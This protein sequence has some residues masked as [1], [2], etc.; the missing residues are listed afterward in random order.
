MKFKNIKSVYISIGA[1]LLVAVLFSSCE[2]YVDIPK[3]PNQLLVTDA[4]KEDATATSAV[5]TLY[6][7]DNTTNSLGY[8]SFCGGLEADELE[9]ANDNDLSMN[10][11]QTTALSIKN[12]TVQ[13]YL[14]ATPYAV[15][16]TANVA[17][18][19]LNNSTTLTPSVKNQLLGESKFFRA[20]TYFYLVNYFGK[21]PLSLSGDANA[22]AFLPRASTD[23]VYAQIVADLKDAQTLLPATYVGT[24][25]ARVNKYAATALLA[26]IYLYMN[27]YTNAEIQASNVIGATDIS[28]TMQD[29]DHAFLNTS[30]EVIF[31]IAPTTSWSSLPILGTYYNSYQQYVL[32]PSFTFEAGDKRATAWT[33]GNI[34]TK[35]KMAGNEYNVTLRLAEQYLIRSEARAQLAKIS[36]AQADLDSVRIRAGLAKT[37]ASTKDDL[38]T[39]IAGERKVELVG[40][41]SH[42]WFDL[43]RTGKADQVIGALKPATWKSTAVLAPIPSD[44]RFKNP[45]LTQ[46][47]GYPN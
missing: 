34:I 9:N 29:I 40:E 41:F 13:N 27:D 5:L 4:F 46:N 31:Q 1:L 35:Y 26:R 15:I 30:N 33:D 25:R 38:L 17:I 12:S 11:F 37:T 23:S 19:G 22:N 44:E 7:N 39:A 10:E 47:D 21:V 36:G 16:G 2:K 18:D 32:A 20:F 14:W 42:R 24:M 3:A 43:K 6:G 45:S 28:Y 8:F